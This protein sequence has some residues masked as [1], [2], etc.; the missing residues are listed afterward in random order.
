M[1]LSPLFYSAVVK[2]FIWVELFIQ[3]AE[4]ALFMWNNEHLVSLIAQNRTVILPIIFDALEMNVQAHWN[5]AVHGLTSNIKRMFME[6]DSELFE[7]CQRQYTQKQALAKLAEDQ[8]QQ[9]WQRL[10]E[11]VA[12]QQVG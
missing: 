2:V 3:V 1:Y 11:S 4:R 6:M 8:R 10:A 5:P 7:E 12:V 9:T